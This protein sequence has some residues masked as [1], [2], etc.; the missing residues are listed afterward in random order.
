MAS[1]KEPLLSAGARRAK[2]V[3]IALVFLCG[4]ELSAQGPKN[5]FPWFE[6]PIRT[7]HFPQV[8]VTSS[9][10]ARHS[11]PNPEIVILDVRRP[12]E[13]SV[14][15]IAGA[16]SFPESLRLDDIEGARALLGRQGLSGLE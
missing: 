16:L 5:S 1:D 6:K 11:S 3:V 15:H 13:Y 14:G 7:A 9:W 8:L 10:L 12:S 4:L 2:G